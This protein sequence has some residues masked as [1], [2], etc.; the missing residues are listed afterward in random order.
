[1]VTS[2]L[3]RRIAS[4]LFTLHGI[5]TQHCT[6][7]CMH[8]YITTYTQQYKMF[9]YIF[10]PLRSCFARC[11]LNQIRLGRWCKGSIH[12]FIHTHTYIHALH[13]YMH[14]GI[15]ASIHTYLHTYIHTYIHIYIHTRMHAYNIN[16][17]H[18]VH[19]YFRT[20]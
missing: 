2:R 10:G 8:T 16:F 11:E 18:Y 20:F 17:V 7:T 9:V 1:M 3:L 13:T 5:N 12:A 14:A 4:H 15:Q 19:T 6:H